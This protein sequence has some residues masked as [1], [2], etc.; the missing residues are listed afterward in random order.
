[1][2]DFI[3]HDIIGTIPGWIVAISTGGTLGI[4]LRFWTTNR[5]LTLDD[6]TNIRSEKRSDLKDCHARLDELG[7]RLDVVEA[8]SHSFEMKLLGTLSA[9]RI[10]E[11]AHETAFPGSLAVQQAR[12]IL[13]TS[14]TLSELPED[15]ATLASKIKESRA[16]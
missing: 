11:L 2:L 10:V 3:P 7:K 8:Q 12:A 5:K 15:M 4:V 6:D 16:A 14:F 9:Y 13:Q 1:M